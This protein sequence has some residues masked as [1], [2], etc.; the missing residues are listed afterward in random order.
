[1]S[2]ITTLIAESAAR[3]FAGEVDKPLLDAAEA[4]TFPT[5]LWTAVA[6]AG[7]PDAL[8]L[9]SEGL[10]PN[11]EAGAAVLVEAGRA[12]APVPL[13]ETM[14]ARWLLAHA[15]VHPPDGPLSIAPTRRQGDALTLA[16]AGGGWTASGR[17]LEVAGAWHAAGLVSVVAAGG[18]AHLVLLAGEDLERVRRAALSGEAH[19]D[20]LLSGRRAMVAPLPAGLGA[21]VLWRA[22]ALARSLQMAGALQRVLAIATGYAQERVQ[23]GR[24]IGKFQAVQQALARLAQET[25]AAQAAAISAARAASQGEARFAVAAAKLRTGEAA[26]IA[27]GIAH[28]VLG[29][30]GFTH[31][32]VLHHL[33][34]RL[35]TW[36]EEFGRESDWARSL[37][38]LA[39][40]TGG[41]GLW[42]LL[43]DD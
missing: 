41:D 42:P 3:L 8:C 28:Q 29:A 20:L 32:H 21:D 12:A 16:A 24:P 36:R 10:W 18:D 7:L 1:M 11:W 40:A 27:A 34:R 26:G 15:G 9:E 6:A 23:F 30:I 35:W 2:E 43:A 39:A 22:G 17:L 33:T 14:I 38:A 25:A 13:A 19:A 5:A 4:G 31:E 37:G